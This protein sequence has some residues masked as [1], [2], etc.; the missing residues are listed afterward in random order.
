MSREV[1]IL[2]FGFVGG[3][4][5]THEG[6]ENTLA[7]QPIKQTFKYLRNEIDE[8]EYRNSIKY[9]KAYFEDMAQLKKD[10]SK[11]K[12]TIPLAEL[13]DLKIGEKHPG[14]VRIEDATT[15]R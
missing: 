6:I 7:G 4:A 14:V 8:E 5:S 12:S 3:S 2:L 15:A 1:G 13:K 10:V 11:Y 9:G